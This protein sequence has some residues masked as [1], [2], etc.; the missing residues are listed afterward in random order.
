MFINDRPFFCQSFVTSILLIF[1]V[2]FKTYDYYDTTNLGKEYAN[3]FPITTILRGEA[4][5]RL[6][7]CPSGVQTDTFKTADSED[8]RN[9]PEYS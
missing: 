7:C 2:G 8:S 6:G 4:N 5:E 3:T 9:I 1:F